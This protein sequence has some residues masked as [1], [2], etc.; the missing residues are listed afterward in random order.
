MKVAGITRIRNESEIIRS[1]L[2]HYADICKEGGIYVYDDASTDD[3]ADICEA[4]PSVKVVIRNKE[5]DTN[6]TRAEYTTRQ[7]VLERAQQDKPD[8]I[9]YFDAD[10]RIDWDDFPWAAN[11]N[12]CDAVRMKLYDYYITPEDVRKDFW[13][14]QWLGPEF[15]RIT[16]M[17]RN[18]EHLKYNRPDQR[19]A[20]MRP[21][22]R[23][24]DAGSVKHYGKAI[25][26]D[27]WEETCDYYMTHF[28][29]PYKTKWA[30]R[31]GKAIHTEM[32]SDFDRP[33]MKWNERT[34]KGVEIPA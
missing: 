15:R 4:H 34:K 23:I 21:N 5:W 14:R 6:R 24:L 29:E 22:A 33:L 30:A 31:K 17:F 26:V 19:M 13:E 20:T 25:S 27:Q 7:A 8:W 32:K 18:D 10:E 16:M 12:N 9:L 1:T 11:F 2:D 3:T 28:P